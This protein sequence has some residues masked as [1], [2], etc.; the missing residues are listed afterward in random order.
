MKLFLG[1]DLGGT[2]IK[3][4]IVTEKGEIIRKNSVPTRAD[5]GC[6]EVISDMAEFSR[7]LAAGDKITAAGIGAPG[8]VD[9]TG[10]IVYFSNNLNWRTVP[11]KAEFERLTGLK[12]SIA[13]D[14]DAAA[15]GEAKFGGGKDYK[16][17][18]FVTLGTGVGGGIIVDGRLLGETGGEIGHIK[19]GEQKRK[20]SCGRLDCWEVYSNAAALAK[21]TREDYIYYLSEGLIDIANIFRPEAIILGGGISYNEWLIEPL[22]KNLDKYIYGGREM[23]PVKIVRATLGNDAGLIGA[24]VLVMKGEN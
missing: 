7:T 13:N 15:L 11:L 1:I 5:A 17:S 12:T 19:I 22:Q 4:G 9:R 23:P 8:T 14:A 20:C 21:D 3:A 18:V 16:N 6:Q 10:G 2:T 24:A